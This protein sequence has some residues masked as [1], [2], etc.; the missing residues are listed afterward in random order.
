MG[1]KDPHAPSELELGVDGVIYTDFFTHEAG[2]SPGGTPHG[3]RVYTREA[4]VFPG[5]H[6]MT[7]K[8]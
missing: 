2:V 7:F 4:G 3:D 1:V 5:E 6:P 8:N